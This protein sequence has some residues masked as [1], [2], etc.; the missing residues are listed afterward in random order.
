MKKIIDNETPL[1]MLTVGEL[2]EVLSSI[3]SKLEPIVEN[4]QKKNFVYGIHGIA[5]IFGCS[6]PTAQKIKSSGTIDGAITQLG[7]L[8]VVD[9]E[10]A[11][12]LAGDKRLKKFNKY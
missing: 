5:S 1:A 12:K 8:I 6:I 4:N 10:L 3:Q 2:K 9:S 7:R 11:L